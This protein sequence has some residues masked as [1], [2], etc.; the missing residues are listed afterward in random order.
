MVAV[1]MQTCDM[2]IAPTKITTNN[3]EI[4]FSDVL[5]DNINKDHQILV[6]R[7][8]Q[9]PKDNSLNKSLWQRLLRPHGSIESASTESVF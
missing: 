8:Q 3:N 1:A 5:H 9:T 7:E 4:S 2:N 6:P